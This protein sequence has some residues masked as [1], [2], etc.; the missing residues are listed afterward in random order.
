MS[1]FE[2]MHL[3]YRDDAIAYEVLSDL[4]QEAL[5]SN[6]MKQ[7]IVLDRML[8]AASF[9][10]CPAVDEAN[11]DANCT[12]CNGAGY[13]SRPKMTFEEAQIQWF[14]DLLATEVVY[15]AHIMDKPFSDDF[16]AFADRKTA[17]AIKSLKHH[18]L[19]QQTA[20]PNLAADLL[21]WLSSMLPATEASTPSD[22]PESDQ[23]PPE[24]LK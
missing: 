6:N 4:H 17:D 5:R 21:P 20:P 3:D 11:H 19:L 10:P 8:R 1:I 18:P 14:K 12:S 2:K 22:K 13:I 15:A 9:I 16:L 23:T 7:Q 24:A